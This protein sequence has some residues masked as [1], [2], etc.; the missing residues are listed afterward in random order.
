VNPLVIA[1]LFI[2]G[3]LILVA[4]W[5]VIST[6]REYWKAMREM[7][8]APGAAKQIYIDAGGRIMRNTSL[9]IILAILS[10]LAFALAVT[11]SLV[12]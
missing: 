4:C 2:G 6:D 7:K 9:I 1:L 3:L 5:V 11:F 10:A 12:H 8:E